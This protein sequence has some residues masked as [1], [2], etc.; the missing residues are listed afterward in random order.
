MID[1]RTK[2]AYIDPKRAVMN[3]SLINQFINPIIKIM[4]KAYILPKQVGTF[5]LCCIILSALA[6]L[7]RRAVRFMLSAIRAVWRWSV[8]K[9]NFTPGDD[10]DPVVLTGA[11]YICFAFAVIV[12]VFVLSIKF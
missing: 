9:H 8:T 7:S 1:A 2:T 12:F 11:Q 6:I 5:A 10:D 4:D 3:H